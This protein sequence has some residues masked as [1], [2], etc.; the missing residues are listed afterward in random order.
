MFHAKIEGPSH[1]IP[2]KPGKL[3]FTVLIVLLMTACGGEKNE[4]LAD[5]K[6]KEADLKSQLS[7]VSAKIHALEGDSGKKF[8]LVEVDRLKPAIFKSYINVQGRVDADESVSLSSEMPGT[9]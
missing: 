3:I 8:A 6:A 7:E 2:V 1:G 9:I 4:S 5:L